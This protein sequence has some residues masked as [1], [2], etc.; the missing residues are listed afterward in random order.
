MKYAERN[1][2]NIFKASNG[3]LE[4]F[5]NRWNIKS[6]KISGV[7]E[8]DNKK[9]A[10]EFSKNDKDILSGYEPKDIFNFDESELFWKLFPDRTIIKVL[11]VIKITL[12]LIT[13]RYR[14]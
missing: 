13:N 3:W 7:N 10:S 11:K 2:I 12:I 1:H 5:Q 14:K 4:K 9:A 6:R 8:S